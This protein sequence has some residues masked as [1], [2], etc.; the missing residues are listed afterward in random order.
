MSTADVVVAILLVLLIIGAAVGL[1][2][3]TR[4][5]GGSPWR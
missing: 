3:I 2:R 4:P 1:E 5:P